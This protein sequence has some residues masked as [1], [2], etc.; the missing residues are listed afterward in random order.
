MENLQLVFKD[1]S[2]MDV[3]KTQTLLQDTGMT[4]QNN[5][6][7]TLQDPPLEEKMYFAGFRQEK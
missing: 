2:G 7:S 3:A 4:V 1:P 5:N 6:P